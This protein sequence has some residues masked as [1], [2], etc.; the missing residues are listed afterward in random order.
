[1]KRDILNQF[2][3]KIVMSRLS[4]FNLLNFCP[5]ISIGN[6]LYYIA[7]YEKDEFI[8]SDMF[9]YSTA[10][11]TSPTPSVI[12]F[13]DNFIEKRKNSFTYGDN[14]K[15]PE[16]VCCGTDY[17][18]R[19]RKLA[20]R[21]SHDCIYFYTMV[22]NSGI[23]SNHLSTS[24][25]EEYYKYAFKQLDM[26]ESFEQVFRSIMTDMNLYGDDLKQKIKNIKLSELEINKGVEI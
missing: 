12:E 23:F 26:G 16:V 24:H 11:N 1:M 22:V 7:F 2:D 6:D 13:L 4:E 19:T 25:R 17:N 21:V 5:Y 20:E 8:V 15:S 10:F 3:K 18:E 9:R 14:I